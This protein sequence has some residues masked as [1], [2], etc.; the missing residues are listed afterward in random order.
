MPFKAERNVK[1]RSTV[2]SPHRL[3]VTSCSMR[4][5]T[6]ASLLHRHAA[7]ALA[8]PQHRLHLHIANRSVVATMHMSATNTSPT[9]LQ[10]SAAEM[11]PGSPEML[12]RAASVK[13]GL[14]RS[15][16][17]TPLEATSLIMDNVATLVLDVRTAEQQAG[18]DINGKAGVTIRGQSHTSYIRHHVETPTRPITHHTYGTMLKPLHGQSHTIHT[19]PC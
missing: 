2:S 15:R 19:A 11:S 12:A 7:M 16:I 18:H 1:R 14:L 10:P 8:A 5:F 3:T 13:A 6:A 17:V 4:G 9:K